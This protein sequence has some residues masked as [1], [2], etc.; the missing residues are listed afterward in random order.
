MK[1]YLITGY[2]GFIWSNSVYYMLKKYQDIL[3]I[4]ADNGF[5]PLPI[6]WDTVV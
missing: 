2:A 6:W 5:T 3:L 4:N 1:K